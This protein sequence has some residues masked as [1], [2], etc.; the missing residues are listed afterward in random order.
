MFKLTYSLF[1][2]IKLK[3]IIKLQIKKHTGLKKI[4]KKN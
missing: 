2:L 4:K 3:K 1:I